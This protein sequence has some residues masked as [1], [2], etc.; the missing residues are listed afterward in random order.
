MEA[1]ATRFAREAGNTLRKHFQTTLAVEYKAQGQRDPVTKA[2]K[3]SEQFLR[4]AI[5]EAYPTHSILGEEGSEDVG[6]EPDFLWALDPV[7]GTVNF[8]NGLP[9]YAVSVGVMYRGEPIVGAIFV[10]TSGYLQEGVFHA[11]RGGG[12]FFDETP[13][14]VASHPQPESSRLS[15]LPA[16]YFRMMRF[17]G[18][19]SRN[20][21]DIRSLG[22]IAVELVL[23][24][25]GTMQYAV[26]NRAKLWDVAAGVLLVKEAGGLSLTQD[27]RNSPWYPLQR[28]LPPKKEL[29]GPE[30]YRQWNNALVVANPEMAW[31]VA[32]HLH[33]RLRVMRTVR[34]WLGKLRPAKRS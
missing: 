15:G 21:G 12:A 32:T 25:N 19:M 8:I 26:F 24:A 3:E 16:N 13:V 18:P 23:V 2:D 9:F 6:R 31:T 11:R 4:A 20:V 1:N 27:G 17:T 34:E 7:D 10:P 29:A 28:F 33:R 22:S 14:A 30:G 5:M